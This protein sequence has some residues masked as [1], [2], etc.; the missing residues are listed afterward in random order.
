MNKRTYVLLAFVAILA[1]GLSACV[2]EAAAPADVD[3]WPQNWF[4]QTLATTLAKKCAGLPAGSSVPVNGAQVPCPGTEE[5]SPP[6]TFQGEIAAYAVTTANGWPIDF[7]ENRQM[8]IQAPE[9]QDLVVNY[10]REGFAADGTQVQVCGTALVPAGS[11]LDLVFWAGNAEAVT[12]GYGFEYANFT[13]NNRTDPVNGDSKCQ[14][15]EQVMAAA[16]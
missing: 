3:W 9:G 4:N 7:G 8:T 16:P 15:W 10:G 13:Y 6:G 2:N 12:K 5:A 14:A 11:K 1:L